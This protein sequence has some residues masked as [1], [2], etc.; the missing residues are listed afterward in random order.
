MWLMVEAWLE[1][2]ECLLTIGVYYTTNLA[3]EYTKVGESLLLRWI[4]KERLKPGY[5]LI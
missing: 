3:I 2:T 1:R 5:H 4:F